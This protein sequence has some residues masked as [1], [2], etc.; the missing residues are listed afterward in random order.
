MAASLKHKVA[1]KKDLIS[2]VA[3]VLEE[4][5]WEQERYI[6]CLRIVQYTCMHTE[7]AA[8]E[9]IDKSVHNNVMKNA[10]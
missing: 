10:K 5:T 3:E 9:F 8:R 2:L 7:S 6:Y 1:V 4:T